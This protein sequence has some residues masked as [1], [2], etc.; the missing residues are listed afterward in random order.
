MQP[1]VEAL[2][3]F[4][5]AFHHPLRH[6]ERRTGG[7]RDADHRPGFLIVIEPQHALAVLEDRVRIL[8]DR[9]RLQAAVLL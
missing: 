9:V 7:E 5:R 3:E 8:D 1:G 4:G 2:G 6:R